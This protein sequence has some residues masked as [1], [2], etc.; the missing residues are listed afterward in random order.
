LSYSLKKPEMRISGKLPH[1]A[2][3]ATQFTP[4]V[5][6]DRLLRRNLS[7]P[8]AHALLSKFALQPL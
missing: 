3:S 7:R 1:R 2:A 6:W 8:C 4:L 5:F